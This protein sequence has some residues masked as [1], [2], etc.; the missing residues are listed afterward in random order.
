M[1]RNIV[2]A[3][4]TSTVRRVTGMTAMLLAASA[5]I[6]AIFVFMFSR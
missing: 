3:V 5:A 6:S 4:K 1:A 2:T